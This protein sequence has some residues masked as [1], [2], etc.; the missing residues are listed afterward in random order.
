MKRAVIVCGADIN[1]Y[2]EL[3]SYFRTGDFF[4]YCDSGLKHMANLVA[5]A[6]ERKSAMSAYDPT[7]E[8]EYEVTC[9]PDLIVGDF[10]SY[11]KPEDS[12]AEVIAL[13]REK[14]D[15]DS[16]RA[17]K[18]AV[19]RGFEEYLI[20]GAVGNRLDHSLVNVYALL[21]LYE[22]GYKAKIVDDYSEM[23]I[24]GSKK[25]EK[26]SAWFNYFS[27]VT[28]SGPAKG[29]TIENAKYPLTD[30]EIS[31]SYQYATS[32]EVA[33]GKSEAYVSVK[34]GYLLLIKDRWI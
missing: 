8:K 23:K 5:S 18:E 22:F 13:P 26:V 29:V 30:A 17:V 20:I 28:I 3:A 11:E 12:D 33:E 16:I 14:D 7:F 27:L 4:I 21:Y 15:T 1:N 34:E 19:K 25:K 24:V 6:E 32:N 31:P 10:D 9:R 2:N